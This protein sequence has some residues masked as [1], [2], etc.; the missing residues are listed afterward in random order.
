MRRILLYKLWPF[1]VFVIY[2][3]SI[4]INELVRGTHIGDSYQHNVELKKQR[5]NKQ[6]KTQEVEIIKTMIQLI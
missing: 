1:Y 3:A 6:R 2:Y 5:A 4:K